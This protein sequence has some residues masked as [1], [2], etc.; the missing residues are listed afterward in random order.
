VGPL[1]RLADYMCCSALVEIVTTAVQRLHDKLTHPDPQLGMFRTTATFS[2][3]GA[4]ATPT[5]DTVYKAIA[6]VV[7]HTIAVASQIP[8]PLHHVEFE[9]F[10]PAVRRTGRN[11]S[12]PSPQNLLL[13]AASFV[14]LQS[15][16]EAAVAESF[17]AAGKFLDGLAEHQEVYAFGSHWDTAAYE[18]AQHDVAQFRKDMFVQSEWNGALLDIAAGERLRIQGEKGRGRVRIQVHCI[19]GPCHPPQVGGG[20]V[21][22]LIRVC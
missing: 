9:T 22:L 19:S 11:A 3:A 12:G 13:M 5:H 7:Q 4:S 20:S 17:A 18:L 8:R 1:I 6:T 16:I 14:R 10:L 21:L 2:E 15:A